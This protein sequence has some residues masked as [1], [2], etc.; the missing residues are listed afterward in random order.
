M[1]DQ[2]TLPEPRSFSR[3]PA[4]IESLLIRQ[5]A[6]M[7]SIVKSAL[8]ALSAAAGTG[9]STGGGRPATVVRRLTAPGATSGPSGP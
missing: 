1:P 7:K 9:V 5:A 3:S 6:S 8:D 2:L 4:A